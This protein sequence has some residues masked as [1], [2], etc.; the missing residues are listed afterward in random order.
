[1]N[2]VSMSTHYQGFV[3]LIAMCALLSSVFAYERNLH[4]DRVD[5]GHYS[6]RLVS[7]FENP[8]QMIL[9]FKMK[10]YILVN[11]FLYYIGY[12]R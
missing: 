2:F 12:S 8:I 4:N 3:W 10:L 1:M 7:V 5:F 6:W 11:L 9:S